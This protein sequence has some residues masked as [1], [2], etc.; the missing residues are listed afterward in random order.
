[1]IICRLYKKGLDKNE[2]VF[3]HEFASLLKQFKKG[4]ILAFMI[5]MFVSVVS[6]TNNIYQAEEA[7]HK[8]ALIKHSLQNLKGVIEVDRLRRRS[9]NKIL[10]IMNRYNEKLSD[11][12]RYKMAHEIYKMTIKYNNLDVDLICATITHESALSW[13]PDIQSWAGAM[14]L[15]QVMPVTGRFL[16]E[17]EGIKWTNAEEIL[18]NPIYNIRLG[19]RYLSM[20]IETYQL[21]GGLAAYNGGEKRVALWLA[22]GRDNNVLYKETQGYIPAV[23]RLYET[24]KN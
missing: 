20:L 22:R 5:F 16:C 4:L 15:M 19:C 10:K 2:R 3:G 7:V 17:L 8:V 12:E 6:F 24:F 9:I 13:R 11:K 18:Y 14:G 23:L 21:E 1:M